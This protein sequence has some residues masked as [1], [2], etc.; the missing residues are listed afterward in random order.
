MPSPSTVRSP[1]ALARFDERRP[2]GNIDRIGDDRT[3]RQSA[4]IDCERRLSDHAKRA[5]VD[6]QVRLRQ[7][8]RQVRPRRRCC[9]TAEMRRERFRSGLRSVDDGNALKAARDQRVDDPSGCAAGADDDGPFPPLRPAGRR[10]VHVGEKA[11]DVSV[12]APQMV[13]LSPQSV[14]RP[15]RLGDRRSPVA[16][17]EGRFLVRGGDIGANESVF[18]DTVGKLAKFSRSDGELFVASRE[19]QFLEPVAMNRRRPRVLDRPARPP[20]RA[21]RSFRS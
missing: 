4:E 14:H 6:E 8:H 1:R 18:A 7:F 16:G 10:L 15:E 11:G 9:R 5:R 19:A 2:Q 12:V 21:A 20:P 3:L 17:A 13:V